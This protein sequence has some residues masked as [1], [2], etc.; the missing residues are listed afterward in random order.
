MVSFAIGAIYTD[1]TLVSAIASAV[2]AIASVAAAI[3]AWKKR[4]CITDSEKDTWTDQAC[5]RYKEV[6]KTAATALAQ[7]FVSP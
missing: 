5:G 6:G 1:Q 4:T 7:T 3:Y 2:F